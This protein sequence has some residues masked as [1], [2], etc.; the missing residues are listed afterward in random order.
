MI[1]VFMFADCFKSLNKSVQQYR[2]KVLNIIMIN[3]YVRR[4][5]VDCN[6]HLSA[7]ETTVLWFSYNRFVSK[8]GRAS[9]ILPDWGQPTVPPETPISISAGLYLGAVVSSTTEY[10]HLATTTESQWDC[11]PGTEISRGVFLARMALEEISFWPFYDFV[12][13]RVRFLGL[14]HEVGRE[15]SE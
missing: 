1:M 14:G 13:V 15:N 9:P 8:G 11:R 3:M 12:P 5:I 6:L 10:L 7:Y 2:T 4:T